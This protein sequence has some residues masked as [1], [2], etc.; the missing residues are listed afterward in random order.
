MKKDEPLC[1]VCGQDFSLYTIYTL[2]PIDLTDHIR[3][4]DAS[5]RYVPTAPRTTLT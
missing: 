1:E 2:N 3:V 5:D 4:K